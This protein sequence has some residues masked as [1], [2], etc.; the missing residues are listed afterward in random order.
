MRNNA[1]KIAIAWAVIPSHSHPGDHIRNHTA[2]IEERRDRL[3]P[4]TLPDRF[5]GLALGR[6]GTSAADLPQ[7][8]HATVLEYWAV[9]VFSSLACTNFASLQGK[10]HHRISS[11]VAVLSTVQILAAAALRLAGLAG[12]YQTLAVSHR[13]PAAG[14]LLTG[15]NLLRDFCSGRIRQYLTAA[16]GMITLLLTGVFEPVLFYRVRFYGIGIV[17]SLGRIFLPGLWFRVW[18]IRSVLSGSGRKSTAG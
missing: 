9:E 14:I 10:R 2:P 3:L 13:R 7:I 11:H 12:L 15:A 4:G 5:H 8:F 6:V 1:A 17:S 18:R 16:I